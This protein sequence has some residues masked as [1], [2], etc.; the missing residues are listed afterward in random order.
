MGVLKVNWENKALRDII[1]MLIEEDMRHSE[2][3]NKLYDLGIT[4]DI[5][6]SGY[7]ILE[8]LGSNMEYLAENIEGVRD[9][10]YTLNE[11]V[12]G[13]LESIENKYTN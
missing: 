10:Y 1:K 2:L 3:F 8:A 7:N 4:V 12:D 9:G 5:D 13:M 6:G 11:F